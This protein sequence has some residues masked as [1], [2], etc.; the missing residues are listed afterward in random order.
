VHDLALILLFVKWGYWFLLARLFLDPPLNEKPLYF[1]MVT[2][3]IN[4]D[5]IC[6]IYIY[7]IMKERK[8][9]LLIKA[10]NILAE[11]WGELSNYPTCAES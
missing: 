11:F 3:F 1:I 8:V 6:K 2:I 9:I 10:Q 7:I 5:Y 4:I